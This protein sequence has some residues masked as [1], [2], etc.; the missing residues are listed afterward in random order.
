[1]IYVPIFISIYL[2]LDAPL[3]GRHGRYWPGGAT[4]GR[5]LVGGPGGKFGGTFEN[6][7]LNMIYDIYIHIHVTIYIYCMFLI[8]KI[9]LRIS[10]DLFWF[11]QS[12]LFFFW[13]I[14]SSQHERFGGGPGFGAPTY[15]GPG[16]QGKPRG[17]M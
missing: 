15:D 12:Y 10:Q 9:C 17:D 7:Y 2:L 14:T 4:S 1:M 8:L 13:D 6:I 5:T 3:M 16:E 11:F